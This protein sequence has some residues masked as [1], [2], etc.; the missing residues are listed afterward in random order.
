MLS[1]VTAMIVSIVAA[2]LVAGACFYLAGVSRMRALRFWGVAFLANAIR[3]VCGLAFVGGLLSWPVI[4]ELWL[5]ITVSCYWLGSRIELRR[6][7]HLPL[8]GLLIAGLLSWILISPVLPISHQVY[9]IPVY[10]TPAAILC[11]AGWGCMRQRDAH[12][13]HSHAAVGLLFLLRGLHLGDY[14]FL[15]GID[16]FAP[17]GFTIGASID[18]ALGIALLV[19][20]HRDATLAA[21]Q[22]AQMLTEENRRRQESESALMDANDRLARQAVDL[23]RL[24]DLYAVQKEEALMA[25]RAKSNFL[26]NMSHEL[27]TPL[28][29]VI[30]FSDLLASPDRQMDDATRISFADDILTSSRRLLHKI[31]DILDFASLDAQNYQAKLAPVVVPELIETCLRDVTA[32]AEARRITLH[33]DFAADLPAID[34]DAAATR[35][36]LVHILDNAIRYTPVGGI[37]RIYVLQLQRRQISIAIQDG[38]PGISREDLAQVLNPFWLAEPTLTKRHGGMGLGL[39]LSRRLIELQGGQ[40]DIASH[41]GAGTRVTLR[42]PLANAGAIPVASNSVARADGDVLSSRAVG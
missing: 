38:G 33:T 42:F 3:Y 2:L 31:N 20:A 37:I 29:A 9:L 21:E 4:G 19:T 1:L 26:A 30:G 27:R 17:Y 24:A 11:F 12:G 34:L 36:A 39:P 10:L 18:L 16:W 5:L 15:R 40:L 32:Q 28:N 14:P 35:K 8:L 41:I 23:E 25:S 22:R 6:P 13:S 7:L